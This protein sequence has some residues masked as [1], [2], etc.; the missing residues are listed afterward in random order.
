[1]AAREPV[2]EPPVGRGRGASIGLWLVQVI[3]AV[4]FIAAAAV[5]KL[6][7]E[8]TAVTMFR[9]IGIG[10]WFRYLVGALEFAGA[11]GL[12]VPRLAGLAALGLVGLMVGAFFTQLLI[13]DGG[14][15]ALTPLILGLV[16]AAIAW[17]RRHEIAALAGVLRR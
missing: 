13:L 16:A 6:I 15:L 1:M 5:P 14:A 17:G 12:L 10:Q 8:E 7:G 4:F 2:S 11:V 9:D 3:L